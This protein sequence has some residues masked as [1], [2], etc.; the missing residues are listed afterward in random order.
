MGAG[1]P[2]DLRAL[3]SASE[4]EAHRLGIEVPASLPL[5]DAPEALR[6][7]PEVFARHLAL[8]VVGAC[9]HGFDR[10]RGLRWALAEGAAGAL[11]EPERAFLRAAPAPGLRFRERV[12]A[13]FALHWALGFGERLDFS[14]GCPKDFVHELPDLRVEEPADA[15]RERA[16]LR[17]PEALAGALD[18]AF[19]LHH[20]IVERLRTGA[21]AWVAPFVVAERRHALEWLCSREEWEAISLDT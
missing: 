15:W 9:A 11:T 13:L 10:Q 7:A 5:L 8:H 1:W 17:P 16:R 20:G 18:L 4:R 12:E 6:S 21:A 19:C 14:C 2:A 3:R